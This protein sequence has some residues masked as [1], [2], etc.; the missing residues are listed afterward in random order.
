MKN[1]S[2][3]SIALQII[4]EIV[5]NTDAKVTSNLLANRTGIDASTIR[6]ILSDL[7]EAEIVNVRPG[8]GGA[9]IIKE[10]SEI[11]MFD[12]YHAVN[13]VD[14]DVFKY[15]NTSIEIGDF[16]LRT[17]KAVQDAFDEI[18]ECMYKKMKGIS[19][20]EVYNRICG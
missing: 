5:E 8:P 18:K 13:T 10:L 1:T 19:L 7:R 6:H 14:S 17:K 2:N 9:T 16:E 4:F 15:Y 12:V 3:Y 20:E 11:S